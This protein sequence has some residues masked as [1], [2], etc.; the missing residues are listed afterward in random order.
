[1][2]GT[3]MLLDKKR[4]HVF[5]QIATSPNTAASEIERQRD[6]MDERQARHAACEAYAIHLAKDATNI[7]TIEAWQDARFYHPQPGSNEVLYTRAGTGG[8]DPTPVDDVNSGI[9]VIDIFRVWRPIIRPVS[10]FNLRN[11]RTFN[12]QPGCTSTTV[13]RGLTAGSI[14]TYA[15]W[16]TEADFFAAFKV[17][18]GTAVASMNDINS[19]AAKITRGLI[20]PDYRAYDLVAIKQGTNQ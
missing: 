18:T 14:A 20:R 17:S 2:Q 9:I 7:V 5:R 4:P 11:G 8:L 12:A 13:L 1:M 15:R 16:R 6:Q 19:F 3:S 10:W